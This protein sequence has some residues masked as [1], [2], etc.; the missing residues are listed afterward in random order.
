MRSHRNLVVI[1]LACVAVLVIGLSSSRARGEPRTHSPYHALTSFAKVLA[2]V[3]A[4]YV[5]DVDETKLIQGAIRGMVRSLDPYSTYMT[6]EEFRVLRSDTQGRFGGIGCEV[7]IRGGV[8]T[9]MIPLEGTPAARAGLRPG[10]RIV[11]I[12]G[13]PTEGM[14]LQE[15]VVRMRGA[16]GSVVRVMIR[17]PGEEESRELS[18]TRA[19]INIESVEA[20]MA[21]PGVGYLRIRSFQENTAARL[22]EELDR[23]EREA[24]GA[25]RALVLDLR[26]DPGGLVDQ[27]VE[28]SDEFLVDGVIV[29][30]RG[31]GG[32]TIAEERAH[33]RGTRPN[34]PMVV[35]V[36]GQS[37]SASEIVTGALQDHR[38]ALIMGTRT[39]GKG[40][41]QNVIE[42]PDGSGLKLTVAR[43]Y[44]PRGRCIQGR[45]IDPDVVVEAPE[46][47]AFSGAPGERREDPQLQRALEHLRAQLLHS[48]RGSRRL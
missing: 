6:P 9:V 12:D 22:R 33:R 20:R 31:R 18:I 47:G 42:L 40:S 30:T 38:R 48:S 1:G 4:S 15:A 36:D 8:L 16:A 39:Y 5:D 19:L 23:L 32:R 35:L 17:R 27:S 28:V 13:E 37:A 34:F 7:D 3:R 24:G 25:L 46:G 11:E 2:H 21:E 43:Y 26:G 29:T 41:V 10:D 14:S 44:T 45:G